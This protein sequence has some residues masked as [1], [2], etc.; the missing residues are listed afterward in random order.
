V[1]G[2]STRPRWP[3]GA[4][5]V[6]AITMDFDGPSVEAGRGEAPLGVKSHGRYA[7]KCGIP[8]YLDLFACH[9]IPVTFYVPGHDAEQCPN[10]VAAIAEAGHE[11]GA[12]RYRHE[13]FDLGDEEPQYLERTHRLLT[14]V[15]GRP[16]R[17]WRSPSGQKA[18]R[19][20]R[21]LRKLGYVYDASDKDFD[22]PYLAQYDGEVHHDFIVL[23]NNTSSLDD[24]PF[25]RVSYTPPSEVL[26]HWIQEFDAIYREGGYFNL[27]LHP[28]AGCGS[29]SPARARIVDQLLRHI[30]HRDGTRFVGMLEIGSGVSRLRTGGTEISSTIAEA[31][32][33]DLMMNERAPGAACVVTVTINLHGMTV[34]RRQTSQDLLFGRHSYGRYTAAVGCS[35]LF[36][37]LERHGIRATVFVPGAAAEEYPDLV[38]DVARRGHDIAA[39]GYAMEEYTG[40]PEDEMLLERTH[41]ILG[42]KTGRAPRGWRAP[43]GHV[44]SQTLASLAAIGY[45]YDA[46]FQ[47]DDVPYRLDRDGGI[48]MIELPQNETLIDATLYGVRQ[49]HDRV[50]KAWRE[51]FDACYAERCTSAR[52]PRCG[53]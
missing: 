16:P 33:A 40:R 11:I 23:P 19:T 44:T 22:L 1:S 31:V 36:P 42:R 9:A 49:P 51:E 18:V 38:A 27:T 7:A 21:T 48:G 30:K 34:E 52:I 14:E 17:G 41:E 50:M 45:L 15:T 10:S 26:A 46:S 24:F 6:V 3:R 29:G 32:G 5:C 20:I 53:S 28:R 47:D 25:Y 2:P 39:H 43:H 4:E 8:R 35:R 13:S 12:H 37:L